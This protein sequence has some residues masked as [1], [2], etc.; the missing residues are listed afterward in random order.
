VGAIAAKARRARKF[1]PRVLLQMAWSVEVHGDGRG[2]SW[3]FIPGFQTPCPTGP[4]IARVLELI[5]AACD[6]APIVF[7][8][9]MRSRPA[10]AQARRRDGRSAR[11]ASSAGRNCGREEI[12]GR[13]AL[14]RCSLGL[15]G[16]CWPLPELTAF[17]RTHG[18]QS[19]YCRKH[20]SGCPRAAG[21][22]G[23]VCPSRVWLRDSGWELFMC[24]KERA[25]LY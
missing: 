1:L 21:Q 8:R 5:L 18:P 24:T 22:F 7:S 25:R 3:A 20:C 6:H 19:D 15:A 12:F 13:A 17:A 9:P 10:R 4:G 23:A 16:F 11:P 2:G 14:L